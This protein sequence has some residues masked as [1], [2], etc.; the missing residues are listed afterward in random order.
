[1]ANKKF[2][3]YLDVLNSVKETIAICMANKAPRDTMI[4][5]LTTYKTTIGIAF[6]DEFIKAGSDAV[7]L[8]IANRTY[9]TIEE[10]KEAFE[11]AVYKINHSN[12]NVSSP[13]VPET[14][15]GIGVG[16]TGAA[17]KPV[18]TPISAPATLFKDIDTVTWAKESIEYLS[19]NGVI[20][21]SGD[22]NFRPN[23]FVTRDEFVKILIVGLEISGGEEM[24]HFE[25]I[26]QT[27]WSYQYAN[28]AKN[29]AIVGGIGNGLFGKG[30]NI[31]RQDM[32]VMIDR[33][34]K[35]KNIELAKIQEYQ[36]FLDEE[37]IG[38]YAIDSIK[39]LYQNGIVSG[40][41]LG[42]FMP[43]EGTTRAQV[44]KVIYSVIKLNI[45]N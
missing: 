13:S 24:N 8:A 5:V 7:A 19:A 43:D 27:D 31:T 17:D 6:D 35:V 26:D 4:S 20:S 29:R 45:E 10:I 2:D 40:M 1:M 28:I 11:S 37:L 14:G 15:G 33:A 32:A 16:I 3:Q 39:K 38:D 36:S 44:A 21:G 12:S 25:D 9:Y 23:D 42:K 34:L 41:G 18:I 22:G 30:L